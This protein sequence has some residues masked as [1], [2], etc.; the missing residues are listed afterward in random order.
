MIP[1]SLRISCSFRIFVFLRPGCVAGAES[2]GLPEFWR[3]RPA[4]SL[5]IRRAGEAAA[6]RFIEFFAATIRNRNMRFAI[7][8]TSDPAIGGLVA[9]FKYPTKSMLLVPHS[10]LLVIRFPRDPATS[11]PTA[12][13][14]FRIRNAIYHGEFNRIDF[15]GHDTARHRTKLSERVYRNISRINSLRALS[16]EILSAS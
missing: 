4:S 15:S 8:P 3:R 1:H 12:P 6:W 16:N 11:S 14:R 13:V 2:A 10:S 9:F 5:I 7:R